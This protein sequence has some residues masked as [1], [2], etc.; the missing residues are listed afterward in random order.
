MI[1]DNAVRQVD[2][3]TI[4]VCSRTPTLFVGSLICFAHYFI[5]F[6]MKITV[7]ILVEK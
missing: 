5:G 7:K 6:A 3:E 4:A 2:N 1:Q